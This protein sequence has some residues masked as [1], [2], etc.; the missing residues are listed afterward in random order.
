M[1]TNADVT[2]RM[3]DRVERNIELTK[4]VRSEVKDLIGDIKNLSGDMEDVKIS[5]QE[6]ASAVQQ[7]IAGGKG[8]PRKGKGKGRGR[9]S[10]GSGGGESSSAG[11][12]S[13]YQKGSDLSVSEDESRGRSPIVSAHQSRGFNGIV[14]KGPSGSRQPVK[15]TT[16]P[17]TVNKQPG[18]AGGPA[19]KPAPVVVEFSLRYVVCGCCSIATPL[20]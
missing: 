9:G 3:A 15:V 5:L 19:K 16:A 20:S 14:K 18:S 4:M 2:L 13:H 1:S 12:R 17:P 10:R 7:Q 8:A 6:I 11:G